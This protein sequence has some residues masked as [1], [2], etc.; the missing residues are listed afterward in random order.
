MKETITIIV[1]QQQATPWATAVGWGFLVLTHVLLFA[2]YV[3]DIE[4][5]RLSNLTIV[6][7]IACWITAAVLLSI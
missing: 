7:G 6:A 4:P 3:L 2:W 5:K 1:T